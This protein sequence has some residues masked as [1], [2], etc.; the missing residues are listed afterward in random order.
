[1]QTLVVR[2][3]PRAQQPPQHQQ[4]HQHQLQQQQLLD[5][6][7]VLAFSHLQGYMLVMVLPGAMSD[8]IASALAIQS[9]Q[10]LLLL[11]GPFSSW[12]THRSPPAPGPVTANT[13]ALPTL[14][15]ATQ[16]VL[17]T[18]FSGIFNQM[19]GLGWHRALPGLVFEAASLYLP[20]SRAM[21]EK[22]PLKLRTAMAAASNV[23]APA[24]SRALPVHQDPDPVLPVWDLFR[25]NY[26]LMYRGLLL[27]S[28][29]PPTQTR[30]LWQLC[31]SLQL[32][33]DAAQRERKQCIVSTQPIFLSSPHTRTSTISTP[34][35]THT[36]SPTPSAT[37][38]SSTHG[39]RD[40]PTATEAR[41]RSLLLLVSAQ[42]LTLVVMLESYGGQV[43][44]EADAGEE[45]AAVEMV[46]QVHANLGAELRALVGSNAAYRSGTST[47]VDTPARVPVPAVTEEAPHT[48]HSPDQA[49][50]GS[51]PGS[52]SLL[53][54]WLSGRDPTQGGAAVNAAPSTSA[55]DGLPRPSPAPPTEVA[56]AQASLMPAPSSSLVASASPGPFP[57]PA[58]TAFM[59]SVDARQGVVKYSGDVPSSQVLQQVWG[60]ISACRARF[61]ARDM[62]LV[63]AP[64]KPTRLCMTV[65]EIEQLSAVH[66]QREGGQRLG[67]ADPSP[68]RYHPELASLAKMQT[69]TVKL[70]TQTAAEAHGLPHEGPG[71]EQP[72]SSG[73]G[74]RG[75]FRSCT[76]S[77]PQL[78]DSMPHARAP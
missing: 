41:Q 21:H 69:L 2:L 67:T 3:K 50:S 30:Q 16:A 61:A 4:H 52:G 13:P 40:T 38:L 66:S 72:P 45:S 65:E 23:T 7:L 78:P 46:R 60:H 77:A 49:P 70:T 75:R 71:G 8:D 57:A 51:L 5:G 9:T 28:S 32:F 17:D 63:E 36:A 54:G 33:S 22:L 25:R 47:T 11:L 35:D 43:A 24:S 62:A 19:T 15:P 48:P 1:M 10:T 58:G 68:W 31:W 59:V 76:R 29:L 20:L 14:S 73:S 26:C 12:A 39:G 34:K 53:V 6:A 37:D 64:P 56:G 27:C 44:A 18:V 55:A 74:R 42:D